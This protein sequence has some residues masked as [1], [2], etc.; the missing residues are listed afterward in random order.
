MPDSFGYGVVVPLVKILIA[1]VVCL[2]ITEI[3]ESLLM[4]LF[5]VQLSSDVLQFG[6]KRK[7]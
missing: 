5:Q 3:F 1:T 7:F 6:F 2:I 4:S